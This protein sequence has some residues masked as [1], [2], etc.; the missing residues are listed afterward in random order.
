MDEPEGFREF[1]NAR[2]KALLRSAWLLTGDWGAAED[3]V[4]VSLAKSWPRWSKVSREGTPELYVRRVMLNTYATWWRRRWRHEIPSGA[5]PEHAGDVDDYAQA[6]A[7]VLVQ[8]ALR[9]LPPRQRATLVLR[10]MDDLTEAQAAEVLGCSVGTVK[11]QTAKAMAHLRRIPA[12]QDVTLEAD[13]HDP[14]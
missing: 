4:Q 1:V 11:S 13:Q 10:F 2:S 7:R 9:G 12:F 5:V 6:D 8:A 14:A 3:L